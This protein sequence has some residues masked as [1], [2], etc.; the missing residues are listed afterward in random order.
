MFN[1]LPVVII[2]FAVTIY[3][4]YFLLTSVWLSAKKGKII[5]FVSLLLTSAGFIGTFIALNFYNNFVLRSLYL[6]CAVLIGWLFYLTIVGI[7]FRLVT[8]FK[9]PVDQKK[10]AVIG[11]SIATILFVIGLIYSIWPRVETIEIKIDNLPETWR[12]QKIVQI[13]DL[14]LGSI[15]GV[16]FL[17][18]IINKIDDLNPDYLFITGDLFDGH[19]G[20][21]SGIGPELKNFA[22]AKKVIFIP[23]NHDKYL[24]LDNFSTY[25]EQANIVSLVDKSVTIDGIEIIG[26]DFL[27]SQWRASRQIKDLR[28]YEGQVRLLLNHTPTDIDEAKNLN[29]ALQLSGHS[30]RGQMWPVSFLTRLIYGQYH[31]GLNSEGSYNIY[32]TS[33]IG[34]WGPPLR[35]FN[36]PEIVQIILK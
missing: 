6:L 9:W 36:R 31:Y 16:N 22:A 21:V 7:L 25:L 5:V 3:V 18:R 20:Q 33:G 8:L 34:S 1:F 24:G 12:G 11:V 2:L 17:R 19:P 32:T 26:Y 23:G 27:D 30:H 14:H 28:P 10:I 15:H 29:I 35:T 4:V 13:S